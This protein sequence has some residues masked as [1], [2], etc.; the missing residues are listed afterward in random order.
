[1]IWLFALMLAL[2]AVA[3]WAA[4]SGHVVHASRTK[5]VMFRKR[6]FPMAGLY[7]DPDGKPILTDDRILGRVSGDSA[8]SVGIRDGDVVVA[9]QMSNDVWKSIRIGDVVIINSPARGI[10]D[11]MRLR[12]VAE[13]TNSELRFRDDDT[14]ALF[15]KDQSDVAGKVEL[16][17]SFG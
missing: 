15:P 17:G 9:R 3:V 11:P 16:A 13:R 4:P 1:M 6:L 12:V 8:R 5:A 2:F 7:Q 14:G 10:D